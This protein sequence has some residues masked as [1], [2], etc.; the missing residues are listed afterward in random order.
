MW[1]AWIGF[2]ASHS[3]GAMLF[4]LIYGYLA[5]AQ[6]N[7]IFHSPF[8]IGVGLCFLGLFSVLGKIYWFTI[9][10]RGIVLSTTLFVASLVVYWA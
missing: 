5:L 7:L 3:Y 4:G 6:S 2:N 10:F 8:L 9:P 1:R